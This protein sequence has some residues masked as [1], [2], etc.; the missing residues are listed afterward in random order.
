MLAQ[1]SDRSSASESSNGLIAGRYDILR[2]LGDGAFAVVYEALDRD[3]G[4]RVALKLFTS[5]APDELEL[6]LREARAMARLNHPN[7]L[8]VHD[9]GEHR[10][11]PFLAI[12]YAQTDLRRWLIAG[13]RDPNEILHLFCEAGR[14]LAA[15]HRADLV[16]HDFKPA[17]VLLRT[18][19]SAAVGDFGL[20]R[21]LDSHD[22]I[23]LDEDDEDEPSPRRG[24]YAVGTLRYIAPERLLGLHGDD[25]SDQFSFC[26]ALW[27]GLAGQHPFFGSDAQ[28]RYESIAAGASGTPRGPA[29]VVRALRRGLSLEAHDRFNSMDDLLAA[30]EQPR[31][32]SP[33]RWLRPVATTAMLSA[34]FLLGVGLSREAPALDVKITP[35]QELTADAAMDRAYDLAFNGAYGD[36]LGVVVAVMPI[37]READA[38][39][40]RE[41]L[42]KLEILG[43]L[44]SEADAHSQAAFMYAGGINLAKRLGDDTTAF[45]AKRSTATAKARRLTRAAAAADEGEGPGSGNGSSASPGGK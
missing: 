42:A 16:H 22:D 29:H 19:G 18:D 27:E 38:H 12:E 34:V 21:H 28:R 6:A 10:G 35:T 2:P 15:A 13:S 3:L 32:K 9:I 20:A 25:R 7:V 11:T 14:G 40:Q 43:D 31:R 4:R 23:C 24:G 36:S 30:L 17:N 39:Y 26:V 8:S 44:L 1:H 45:E 41:Y 33:V 5:Y 37:V